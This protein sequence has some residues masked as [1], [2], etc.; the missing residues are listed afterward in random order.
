[1]PDCQSPSPEIERL[2]ER[3]NSL[4]LDRSGLMA[5]IR[6]MRDGRLESRY[7]TKSL[8]A[9]LARTPSYGVLLETIEVEIRCLRE[10]LAELKRES[11][12]PGFS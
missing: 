6:H 3:I 2:S 7:L 9:E 10:R 11:D 12:T 8:R 1:M 5:S 4:E